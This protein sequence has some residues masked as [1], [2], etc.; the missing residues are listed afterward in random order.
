MVVVVDYQQVDWGVKR[1]YLGLVLG[2]RSLGQVGRWLGTELGQVDGP[3]GLFVFNGLE[4][5]WDSVLVGGPR[6]LVLCFQGVRPG[7]GEFP[8]R[9]LS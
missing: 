6:N 2:S 3:N 7:F 5:V 9:E 8:Y 4:N 1:D